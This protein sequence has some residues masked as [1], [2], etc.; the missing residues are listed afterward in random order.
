MSKPR[1][2]NTIKKFPNRGYMY[3]YLT[4]DTTEKAII[5]IE[6]YDKLEGRTWYR[7]GAKAQYVV[8]G[9]SYKCE[10]TGER[11]YEALYLHRVIM[12]APAN[13]TVDHINTDT[14]DCRKSNLRL[15]TTQENC[16]NRSSK[17][18]GLSKYKGLCTSTEGRTWQARITK[19]NITTIL[20][21][22]PSERQAAVAYDKAAIYLFK[23]FARCNFERKLYS[24]QEVQDLADLFLLTSRY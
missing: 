20:G 14:F 10:E 19:D 22:Y 5:D 2:L 7:A 9:K 17:A 1:K 4:G 15:A 16:W 11:K 24:D 12:D 23:D 8:A 6:D 21:S 13:L 18:N 3:I